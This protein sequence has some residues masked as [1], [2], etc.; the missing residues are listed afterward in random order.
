M[1]AASASVVAVLATQSSVFTG[2]QTVVA[3]PPSALDPDA[4]TI[5]LVVNGTAITRQYDSTLVQP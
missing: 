1:T 3:L 4:N 2:A 5:R